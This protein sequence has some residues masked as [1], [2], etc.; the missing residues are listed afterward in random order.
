MEERNSVLVQ[1]L[2]VLLAVALLGILVGGVRLPS[3]ADDSTPLTEVAES[4]AR[5][6]LEIIAKEPHAAGTEEAAQVREYLRSELEALGIETE[7]VAGFVEDVKMPWLFMQTASTKEESEKRPLVDLIARIPGRGDGGVMMIAC[8]YDSV[9]RGEN[10]KGPGAGDDGAAAASMLEIA[11]AIK[12]GEPLA[13][14]VWLLFTDGEELG[15]LGAELFCQDPE[16]I[17][18][19][20]VVFNFEGIGNNGPSIMFQTSAGNSNLIDAF[21]QLDC[22]KVA[23]S[24]AQAIYERMPNDTDF[25]VFAHYGL[26]GLNFAIV[27]GRSAYH[28]AWDTPE[29]LGGGTLQYQLDTMHAL[30]QH[31]GEADLEALHSDSEQMY[32]DVLGSSFVHFAEGWNFLVMLAA[33]LALLSWYRQTR[34]QGAHSGRS[35]FTTF[36]LCSLAGLLVLVFVLAIPAIIA[37]LGRMTGFEAVQR[38]DALSAYLLAWGALSLG[39]AAVLSW[40]RRAQRDPSLAA[41]RTIGVLF[42]GCVLWWLIALAGQWWLPIGNYFSTIPLLLLT[43]T[44]TRFASRAA[45]GRV[46]HLAALASVGSLVLLA[47]SLGLLV[48]LN[49][50]PL[51]AAAILC[52]I[53]VTLGTPLCLPLA[54]WLRVRERAPLALAWSLALALLVV[55]S[56]FRVAGL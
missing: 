48:A 3:P 42:G 4:R 49:S 26:I 47:P 44:A 54:H 41:T 34:C 20:D 12:A 27:G 19:I 10:H 45:N 8:H 37:S 31:F 6:H 24:F 40:L 28:H 16:R 32:F 29:N 39:L 38:G 23:P 22:A 51:L 5:K 7:F 35:L 36:A 33:C 13:N 2:R 21:A 25:T 52:A 56:G 11:R 14:D 9:D 50:Q 55:A 15:L 53:A 43:A 46:S 30:V 17:A 18:P 1:S